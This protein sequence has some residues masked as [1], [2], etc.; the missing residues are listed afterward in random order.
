MP[1]NAAE[2][3]RKFTTRA[4][5]AGALLAFYCVGT[6][7]MTGAMLTATTSTAEAQWRGRGW[8]GG[9]WRGRG[10]RGRGRGWGG[11]RGGSRL[12]CRH[13]YYSSRRV[14]WRA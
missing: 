7:T 2:A 12:V 1:G 9:G 10:Y 14:C 13:R 8:R 11:W 3:V 5:A 6:V 4:L